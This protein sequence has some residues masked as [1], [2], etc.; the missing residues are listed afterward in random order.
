MNQPPW[1][2]QSDRDYVDG[3]CAG[4]SHREKIK[5]ERCPYVSSRE[6]GE[7][8]CYLAGGI[9]GTKKGTNAVGTIK[10]REARGQGVLRKLARSFHG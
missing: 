8:R 1:G 4:P 3:I 6:R 2:L 9:G 5:E 10:R 7:L